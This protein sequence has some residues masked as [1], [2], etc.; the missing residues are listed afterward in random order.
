MSKY[1]HSLNDNK[2]SVENSTIIKVGIYNHINII[3]FRGKS[4]IVN[5][6]I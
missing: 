2:K 5:Y 1:F 3:K 6:C 4:F